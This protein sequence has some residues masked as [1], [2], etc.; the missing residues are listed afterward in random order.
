MQA[1]IQTAPVSKKRLWAGRIISALPALFLL[2]II[3]GILYERTG[4]LLAPIAAHSLFNT[5][6]LIALYR[7]QNELQQQPY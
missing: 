5:L 3:L 6:N 7:F 2:A 4:N 1:D